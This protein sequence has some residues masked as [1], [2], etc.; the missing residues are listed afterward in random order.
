[1]EQNIDVK[2]SN[3]ESLLQNAKLFVDNKNLFD[4]SFCLKMKKQDRLKT[5]MLDRKAE[6]TAIQTLLFGKKIK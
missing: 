2:I 4:M 3:A 1:M 5:K 6:L